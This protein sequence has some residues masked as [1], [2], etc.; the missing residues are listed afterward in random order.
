MA[1]E[2]EVFPLPDDAGDE[3]DDMLTE[4]QP[5]NV[6]PTHEGA[7]LRDFEEGEGL[8]WFYDGKWNMDSFFAGPSDIQ[9]A[10]WRGLP[11]DYRNIPMA[12]SMAGDGEDA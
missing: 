9:D 4:W 8:S 1:D 12:T 5:G 7:Y 6:L 2:I 10:P 3:L 11:F